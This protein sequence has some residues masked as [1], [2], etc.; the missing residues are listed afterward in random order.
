MPDNRLESVFL[1]SLGKPVPTV[2]ADDVKR[3]WSFFAVEENRV[4]GEA[5]GLNVLAGFCAANANVLAV[6]RSTLV[7]ILVRQGR[8]DRWRA[9]NSLRGKVFEVASRFPL[10]RGPE[11][12]DLNGFIAAL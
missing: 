5:A 10:P 4:P 9:G 11:N 2:E 3:V 8:L 6:F 7:D 1:Q 12:A